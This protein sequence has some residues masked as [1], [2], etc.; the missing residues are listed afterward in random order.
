MK[1]RRPIQSII[2]IPE[3]QRCITDRAELWVSLTLQAQFLYQ[4]D[5]NSR[6]NPSEPYNARCLTDFQAL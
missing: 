2:R 4:I 3:E 6:L 1:I 5:R